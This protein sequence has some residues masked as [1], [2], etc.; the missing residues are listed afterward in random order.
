M[1][2]TCCVC[3]GVTSKASSAMCRGCEIKSRQAKAEAKRPRC[4]DC[5][6]P[7]SVGNT[8]VH[9]YDCRVRRGWRHPVPSPRV[10]SVRE[11]L[12]E[13]QRGAPPRIAL[14]NY[15]GSAIVIACLHIPF[16]SISWVQEV[17][18]TAELLHI[19]TLVLAGDVLMADRI[20][21]YDRVG[22]SPTIA[23]ELIALR[24]VMEAFGLVFKRIIFV[25]GNHDQRIEKQ[26]AAA[27]ETKTGRN[28]LDMVA[29]TLGTKFD[30]EDMEALS[31]TFIQSFLP[32]EKVYFEPLPSIIWNNTYMVQHA[33]C[34]RVPPAHERAMAAKHRT[35]Q[36]NGNSHL[37]GVGFDTSGTDIA[38]TIGH[39]CEPERFRYIREKPSTFPQQVRGAAVILVSERTGPK[40]V[41]VPLADHPRYFKVRDILEAAHAKD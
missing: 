2:G 21:K 37:W 16:Y 4:E 23:E 39:S 27:A 10:E 29:A 6:K 26:I 22:K 36:L 33:G 8:G 3:G 1:K 24:K 25:V 38:M 11:V 30:P 9:C 20:S 41:V 13:Q 40:G 19:D 14:N 31:V 32:P 35:S 17:C 15:N 28:T 18:E 5:S 34:S 7:L 12:E